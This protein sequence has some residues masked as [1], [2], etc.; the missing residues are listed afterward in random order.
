MCMIGIESRFHVRKFKRNET[1]NIKRRKERAD[2]ITIYKLMIDLEETDTR[3]V[4]LKI[5]VEKR[6]KKKLQKEICLHDTKKYNLS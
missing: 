6:H 4:I 5:L 3:N 1:N 2:L